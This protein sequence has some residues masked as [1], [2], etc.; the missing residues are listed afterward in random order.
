MSFM[1]VVGVSGFIALTAL[2]CGGDDDGAG[3]A[4]L[5]G[6][7]SGGAAAAG[8]G[9]SGGSAG[10]AGSGGSAG[11]AGS[12][13]SGGGGVGASAG[14]AGSGGEGG[15]CDG[16]YGCSLELLCSAEDCGEPTSHFDAD[17]C[18]R[19]TC[20]S[21]A[22]CGGG[23][24]CVIWSMLRAGCLA[25]GVDSCDVT[26]GACGCF[27]T[28]DCHPGGLC[29]TEPP[30]D[31]CPVPDSCTELQEKLTG[32]RSSA[33]SLTGDALTQVE[34]CLVAHE[35]RATELSCDG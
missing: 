9:A 29:L 10:S 15:A 5:S 12:A 21:D 6:G 11:S 8:A 28:A 31:R 3:K 25:S 16:R 7:G 34:S 20:Q 13:G 30:A 27:K 24:T 14:S 23:R 4:G 19:Q 26:E 22:E 17:G 32:L 2:G 18:P 33:S 1:R 35:T